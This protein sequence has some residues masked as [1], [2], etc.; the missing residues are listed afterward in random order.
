MFGFFGKKKGVKKPVVIV[1]GLPR[2]GTSMMMQILEAG[3]LEVLSDQVRQ[4]DS[5]NPRG[6]Y[7]FEPVKQTSSDSS[8]LKRSGGKAVK[9]VYRLLYDLPDDYEYL[10]VFMNRDLNEVLRSQNK[11]LERLGKAGAGEDDEDM[12]VLFRAELDKFYRWVEGKDNIR[13]IYIN[14]VD[15]ISEPFKQCRAVN[16]FLGGGLDVDS[17]AGCVDSSLY[18]NRSK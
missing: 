4:A 18:R 12:A 9:M 3:G 16:A 1:S 14:Y 8:W 17:M 5:D 7:E 2:S 10:V 13:I 6:Y 15:V 11:M